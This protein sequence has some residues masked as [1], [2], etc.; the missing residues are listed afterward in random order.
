MWGNDGPV[1][2]GVAMAR[3]AFQCRQV[4]AHHNPRRGAKGALEPVMK[5]TSN[6][7]FGLPTARLTLCNQVLAIRM[8]AMCHDG[9]VQAVLRLSSFHTTKVACHFCVSQSKS[10]TAATSQQRLHKC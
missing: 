7:T 9:D 6:T 10:I 2:R 1:I 4:S 5:T 3:V 8:Q